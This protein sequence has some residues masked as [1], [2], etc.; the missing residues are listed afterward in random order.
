MIAKV[1]KCPQIAVLECNCTR[2]L[3]T[4]FHMTQIDAKCGES[5]PSCKDQLG[6]VEAPGAGAQL[7]TPPPLGQR[8]PSPLVKGGWERRPRAAGGERERR[9]SS[10]RPQ[11]QSPGEGHREG[12]VS[13]MSL[14]LLE[15]APL[16]VDHVPGGC[17]NSRERP[18]MDGDSGPCPRPS[19][20]LGGWGREEV[21]ILLFLKSLIL[22]SKAE[23]THL[24]RGVKVF[25][26][27]LSP[28]WREFRAILVPLPPRPPLLPLNTILKL[29]KKKKRY[30]KCC[31]SCPTL[32]S[33]RAVANARIQRSLHLSG[34]PQTALSGCARWNMP[35]S[36]LGLIFG[37]KGQLAPRPRCPGTPAP[38]TIADYQLLQTFLLRSTKEAILTSWG[39]GKF[40]ETT[41][42]KKKKR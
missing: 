5:Q 30:F 25:Y 7:G 40:K 23:R 17:Q 38:A 18:N 20:G 2:R 9:Q 35:F 37:S 21:A 41:L 28:P 34:N 1:H 14:L 8:P 10:G 12:S 27:C 26:S 33:Q 15:R 39:L 3:Q 24:L 16:E 6:A 22:K 31:P 19:Q 11:S 29:L 4:N 13:W 32:R 42:L 36:G